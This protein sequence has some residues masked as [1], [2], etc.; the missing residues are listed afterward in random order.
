[1][2]KTSSL[3]SFKKMSSNNSTHN[4]TKLESN[5]LSQKGCRKVTLGMR[6]IRYHIR[7]SVDSVHSYKRRFRHNVGLWAWV[8]VF[9]PLGAVLGSS[10]V[11]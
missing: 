8:S 2:V 4:I 9:W 5:G 11:V 7:T 6:Y 3:V 1:M 10:G